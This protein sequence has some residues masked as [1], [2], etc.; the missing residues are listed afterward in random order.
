MRRRPLHLGFKTLRELKEDV[1]AGGKSLHLLDKS[2]RWCLQFY[3]DLTCSVT[4]EEVAEAGG[5]GGGGWG[6]ATRFIVL[7]HVG[8]TR[9]SLDNFR[10][11][12]PIPAFKLMP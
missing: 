10:N 7:T 1:D 11:L 5:G 12:D 2:Q 4:A 3:E 6:C 8:L 9:Y